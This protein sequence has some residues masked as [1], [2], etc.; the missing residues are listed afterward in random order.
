MSDLLIE[1]DGNILLFSSLITL[2]VRL[3]C[4][5]TFDSHIMQ[6]CKASLPPEENFIAVSHSD[7]V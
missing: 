6:L 1:H 5:L 4:H 7:R 2:V 3:Y